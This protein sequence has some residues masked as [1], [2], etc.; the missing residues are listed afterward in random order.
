MSDV[1]AN[2]IAVSAS[3][4]IP[5]VNRRSNGVVGDRSVKR[6]CQLSIYNS[7]DARVLITAAFQG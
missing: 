6:I 7:V 1:Y 3:H 4:A 5:L 2:A